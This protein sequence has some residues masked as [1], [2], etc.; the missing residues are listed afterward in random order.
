MQNGTM[1]EL[2]VDECELH[3]KI[4]EAELAK[5]KAGWRGPTI[6]YE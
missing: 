2:N 3:L 5:W 1:I 4:S 6:K